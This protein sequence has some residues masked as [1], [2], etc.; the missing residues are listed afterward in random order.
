MNRDIKYLIENVIDYLDKLHLVDIILFGS[1]AKHHENKYSDIDLLF[2]FNEM[3]NRNNI[4]NALNSFRKQ[5]EVPITFNIDSSLEYHPKINRKYHKPNYINH[6]GQYKQNIVL[7]IFYSSESFVD[8][9][10]DRDIFLIEVFKH[11]KSLVL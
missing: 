7:H 11:G 9:Y 3:P 6:S 2:I 10:R 4:I 5:A 8:R 1:Y